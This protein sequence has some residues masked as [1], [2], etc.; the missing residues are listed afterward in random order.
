MK[1]YPNLIT[2]KCNTIRTAELVTQSIP[3]LVRWAKSGI[4]TNTYGDLIKELGMVRFSG[5][6]YTL[7]CIEDV[8]E[9]LREMTGQQI[10]TLN[11]LVRGKDGLP[12]YGFEYVNQQY[13]SMSSLDKKRYVDGVNKETVDF[14]NWDLVLQLLEL[15]PSVVS[16]IKDETIIRSGLSHGAGEGP[17]HKALKEY[18][19]AHP[20]SIYIRNVVKSDMEYILLSGDRL[21]I[22]FE[23][24][25][26]TRIAVEV[27]SK[28]SADDDILRGL[29]QCVKYKAIL[30]AENKTHGV[31]GNT[32]S[33]LV[34]EGALSESNQQVKDSLGINVIECFEQR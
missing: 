8:I 29:Y 24:K 14:P 18:I 21:D 4:T 7:G 33:L 26:G 23:Q 32:R 28:I 17:Q 22:Y 11:A 25:D 30:D 12:S 15:K 27:K 34:I 3:I 10:P 2:D 16:S 13:P 1:T 6:G 5:I 9:A 20:E 31:F 19:C